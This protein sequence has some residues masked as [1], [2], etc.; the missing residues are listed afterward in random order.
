MW[1]K[2]KRL[3]IM[4][5]FVVMLIFVCCFTG[6]TTTKYVPMPVTVSEQIQSTTYDSVL[7]KRF[8]EAFEKLI[9]VHEKTNETKIKE[10]L[11]EK[12]SIAPIYD[13]T[14]KKVGEDR[15]HTK[16][17]SRESIEVSNLQEKLS[18]LQTYKDSCSVYK[19]TID[20]L[21]KVKEKVTSYYIEKKLNVV[22]KTLIVLGS[23]FGCIILIYLF[24]VVKNFIR[25]KLRC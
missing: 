16:E 19:S 20:S 7:N 9:Q 12:D 5:L 25:M 18:Y 13:D 6:C 8:V 17:I 1:Y 10:S 15:F 4:T 2:K 11:H 3:K 23:I 14:G 21:N 22:Q 24:L